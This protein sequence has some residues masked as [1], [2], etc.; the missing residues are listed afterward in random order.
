[1]CFICYNTPKL[2]S[3]NENTGEFD[4]V[5]GQLHTVQEMVEDGF[6]RHE[7]ERSLKAMRKLLTNPVVLAVPDIGVTVFSHLYLADEPLTIT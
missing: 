1:M 3:Y 6:T 7:A 4:R 5:H 2:S